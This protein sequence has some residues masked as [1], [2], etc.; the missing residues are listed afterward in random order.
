MFSERIEFVQRK[1]GPVISQDNEAIFFN[2]QA[3]SHCLSLSLGKLV[4]YQTLF[5]VVDE[6]ERAGIKCVQSISQQKFNL[7]IISIPNSKKLAR[8]LIY[9]ATKAVPEGLIIVDLSLIHI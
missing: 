6:L 2:P 5:P 9:L 8:H 1:F 4:A 3:P 7:A